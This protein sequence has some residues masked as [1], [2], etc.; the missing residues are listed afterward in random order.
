MA[1]RKGFTRQAEE[2]TGELPLVSNISVINLA[3]YIDAGQ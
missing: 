1:L 2:T 3:I